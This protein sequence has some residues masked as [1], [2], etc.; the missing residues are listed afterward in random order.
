MQEEGFSVKVPK[1][2]VH[3]LKELKFKHNK[4]DEK[5]NINL[6]LQLI[7]QNPQ[8]KTIK[9]GN[10]TVDQGLIELG[11]KGIYIASL[12]SVVRR[13]VPNRVIISDSKNDILV[14]RE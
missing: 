6:A 3:E 14:E 2:V 9:L 8:I 7:D 5:V 13:S 1:E 10:K 12:D 11:R 4:H